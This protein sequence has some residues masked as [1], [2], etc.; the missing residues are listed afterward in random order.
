MNLPIFSKDA[1]EAASQI[2]D[3]I[4]EVVGVLPSANGDND[5]TRNADVQ[6]ERLAAAVNLYGGARMAIAIRLLD[7]FNNHWHTFSSIARENGASTEAEALHMVLE[8]AGLDFQVNDQQLFQLKN[9]MCGVLPELRRNKLVSPQEEL[10]YVVQCISDA[11]FIKISANMRNAILFVNK[12]KATGITPEDAQ[13]IKKALEQKAEVSRELEEMASSRK[14]V[15]YEKLE[16]SMTVGHE[17]TVF[18]VRAPKAMERIVEK[19]ME[20]YF[21]VK[22]Y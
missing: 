13:V 2:I 6:V 11:N 15:E 14:K 3:I 16:C 22:P 5:P 1:H 4:D 17:E 12:N 9:F 21:D 7:V 18:V 19:F 8:H 20:R 10:E